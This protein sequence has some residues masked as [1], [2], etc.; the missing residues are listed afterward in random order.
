MYD[1]A[2]TVLEVLLLMHTCFRYNVFKDH[3]TLADYEIHDGA[4]LEL[5]E[6]ARVRRCVLLSTPFARAQT[7]VE[8]ATAAA[9]RS[10]CS[11]GCCGWSLRFPAPALLSNAHRVE[12]LARA[13]R[14]NR[15]LEPQ[16]SLALG[17]DCAHGIRL[18]ESAKKSSRLFL[19]S[20]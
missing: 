2:S 4:G 1:D 5:C 17:I 14:G 18:E 15:T 12:R 10:A 11:K 3:I 13:R 6:L 19:T 8:A 16:L 20:A 9:Q 7:T